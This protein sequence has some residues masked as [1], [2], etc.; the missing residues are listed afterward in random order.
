MWM[1]VG[2]SN[3]GI[4]A[5]CLASWHQIPSIYHSRCTIAKNVTFVNH[6]SWLP[7]MVS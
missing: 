5:K 7:V 1:V 2:L 4:G 3:R 6:L